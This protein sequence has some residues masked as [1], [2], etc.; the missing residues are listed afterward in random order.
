MI[1]DQVTPTLLWQVVPAVRDAAT[2]GAQVWPVTVAGWVTLVGGVIGLTV[3][4]VGSI[5]AYG[6]FLGKLNG[7]GERVS[8]VEKEQAAAKERDEVLT[9]TMER[10]TQAQEHLLEK[11]GQAERASE[12]CG[13][14]MQEYTIKVGTEIHE[15]AKLIQ[16]EGREA[17]ERLKGVET[18]LDFIMRERDDR[19]RRG[20]P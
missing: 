16:H 2:S 19:Y 18:K 15:L 10:M 5:I 9:R 20:T 14:S 3:T 12:Q 4:I 11:I 1:W 8:V 6:K 17:G 13:D 7:F